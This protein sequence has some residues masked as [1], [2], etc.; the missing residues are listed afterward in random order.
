M[1]SLRKV[2]DLDVAG[3]RVFVRVDF[4]VPQDS[5][6]AITDDTRIRAALPTILHLVEQ[7]ARV[8]LGSHL[9]RPKGKTPNLT[10]LSIGE[11]LAELLAPKVAEIK[12]CDEVVGDGVRKVVMDLRNGEVALLENLRWEPGEEKNDEALSKSLA[13]LFEVY[14]NDAFGT[15]HRAHCSTAGMAKYFPSDRRGAGF[16]LLR[17]VEFLSRLLHN[18]ERPYVVV[19]GGAKVSDKISVLTNLAKVASSVLI[20]GAM[21]NTFLA[22]QGKAMG[23][24]KLEADKLTVAKQFLER[25][26]KEQVEVILPFDL[27]V[28]PTVDSTEGRAVEV[29]AVPADEMA[30]DIG[31]ATAREFASRI[32]AAKTVFW[33]G[34][35]GLFEKKPFSDGTFAVARAMAACEGTTVV[36]GGDSVAAV[37]EAGLDQNIT[38]VSTGGGASLEFVEGQTLPGI[39]VLT[40]PEAAR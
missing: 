10:M 13:A 34:P 11:R 25:C 1:S 32:K 31:P 35:L 24:S 5:R 16:L 17:E 18:V 29:D 28:A 9:G 23:K 2:S 15:A 8:V 20:G 4:N 38:H 3:K 37:S 27:V 39:A 36:G 22:A 26:K 14:V 21:A 6:G 7:G 40:E 33:N 30:L 19:V 12:L